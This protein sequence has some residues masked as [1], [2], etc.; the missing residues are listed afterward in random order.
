MKDTLGPTDLSLVERLSSF[1][2]KKVL[3][4]WGFEFLA[5]SVIERL[6]FI[7]SVLLSE[8]PL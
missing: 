1:E 6:S 4:L 2:V 8:V 3:A 5:M 7:W